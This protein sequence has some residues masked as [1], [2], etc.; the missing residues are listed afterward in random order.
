[1]VEEAEKEADELQQ[2]IDQER[3]EFVYKRALELKAREGRWQ[4]DGVAE[5]KSESTRVDELAEEQKNEKPSAS[6]V[7]RL[8]SKERSRSET[9]R[10]WSG[11][12]RTHPHHCTENLILMHS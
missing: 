10:T 9:P 4:R 8:F 1:M 12:A 3:R 11:R 7:L 5:E 6:V 2:K